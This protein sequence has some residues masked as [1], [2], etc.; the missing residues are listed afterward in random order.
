M[1]SMR[2]FHK[3]ILR[4]KISEIKYIIL[5]SKEEKS[6][7]SKIINKYHG[8]YRFIFIFQLS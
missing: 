1:V 3:I 6:R 5:E 7:K 8:L 4:K 2:R